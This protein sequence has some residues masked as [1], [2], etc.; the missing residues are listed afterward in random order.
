MAEQTPT[1][2]VHLIVG[3]D[4]FLTER[5]ARRI[6]DAA[7]PQELRGSA[8][9]TVDGAAT[10]ADAQLASLRACDASVRTPP[11][12][13]P[14]KATWWRGVSFL[15][16][17]GKGGRVS[18]DVKAA[19]EKF[20]HA[21]AEHRLPSN[22]VF[23]ITAPKCLKTSL[24]AKAFASF[25]SVVEFASA[26]RSGARQDAALGRLAELAEEEGL[27]FAPGADAAFIARTGPDSRTIVSELAKLHTY[28]GPESTLVTQ[29]AVA[30][31]TSA[32]AAEPELWEVTDAVGRR[33]ARQLLAVLARYDGASSSSGIML[34]TVLERFFRELIVVRDA[35]DRKWLSQ[36]GW[37]RS[38][39]SETA[40]MLNATGF[41][42]SAGKKPWMLKRTVQNAQ[43]FSPQELR[44]ARYRI[45]AVREKL[46]S[47][48]AD[49]MQL[50]TELLRIIRRP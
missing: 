50:T 3:E 12:L 16:G 5:A 43:A 24:F 18:E 2:N 30:A 38:L 10:N 36:F 40:A 9:E 23:V 47:G 34:A 31:I 22:Q 37:S 41:G 33:S 6:L 48:G 7:V 46:V 25:A 45:L 19:L 17:G 39:P 42:P 44:L 8:I 13:D 27:T 20:A 26:G 1:P 28:L 29:E 49:V 11:F 14:V 32:Q 4:D 21:L 35:V 15:P